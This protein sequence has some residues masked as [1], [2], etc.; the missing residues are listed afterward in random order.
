MA[1]READPAKD[2]AA[3]A[4]I[5]APYVDPGPASFEA[6]PPDAEE[7]RQRITAATAPHAWLVAELDGDIAGYAYSSPHNPRD[8]YRWSVNVSVYLDPRFHR[9]GV[10][11]ELYT[12]L[13]AQLKDAGIRQ[14]CAGITLP[15]DASVGLHE[16]MGFTLVGV[17][18][19]IGY[20]AGQWRDVGWWQLELSP[21]LRDVPPSA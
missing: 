5:Y 16:A 8:A 2:S 13:L 19:G 21:E 11:R 17:Y 4:G 3:C 10:G 12:Q 9:R 1:V 15:N 18:Q 14:A 20:K 7:M 6:S